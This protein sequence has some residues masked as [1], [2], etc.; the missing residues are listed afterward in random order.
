[1]IGFNTKTLIAI[2]VI[3]QSNFLFAQVFETTDRLGVAIGASLENKNFAN[4]LYDLGVKQ[5]HLNVWWGEIEPTQQ[6]YDYTIIDT[7]LEKLPNDAFAIFRISARKNTWGNIDSPDNTVPADLSVNGSFY[8][9]VY[10]VVIRTNGRVKYFES[11]W[12]ADCVLNH[13]T[14]TASEYAELSRTFYKAVKDAD[15]DAFVIMGG[16]AGS[17]NNN[18]AIANCAQ[19]FFDTVFTDLAN[20]SE[21]KTF[22]VFDIHLYDELYDI[23]ERVKYFRNNLDSYPEFSGTPIIVTEYGGPFP[24][25]FRYVDPQQFFDLTNIELV[26]DPCLLAGDL[27]NTPLYPGGYSNQLRMMFGYGIE[28]SLKDKRDRIQGRQMVQRT[29]LALSEGV[30]QLYWWNIATNA[31]W[32][33]CETGFY[34]HPIFGKMPLTEL[35]SDG[36][37]IPNPTY[38]YYQTMARYLNEVQSVTRISNI[39]TDIYL[40]EL[41]YYDGSIAYV[42]W[43]R[44]DQ[45]SGEDDTPIPFTFITPWSEVQTT[46]LFKEDSPNI[47]SIPDGQLTLQITDTPVFI[48]KSTLTPVENDQN[49]AS[50]T[51]ELKQN[52][53]NPFNTSTKIEY[54]LKVSA[55]TVLRIYDIFG[56]EISTLIDEMKMP[57]QHSTVWNG[58]DN[59]GNTVPNGIYFLQMSA[60]ESVQIKRL[61]LLK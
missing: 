25:E 39:N 31:W 5:T 41:L 17:S 7:F 49:F 48:E 46:E 33:Q 61:M 4:P 3:L 56:H 27:T 42:A 35:Q 15:S 28:S 45:F 23:P 19:S 40:Y 47:Y 38:Y 55:H 16:S 8:N 9:Y 24:S 21:E 44:R 36:T 43:E 10:N 26:N 60:G 51:F 53:P 32:A 54:E 22:D 30:E 18:G 1:M 11:E 52:Y 57:G 14:G 12:E 59:L 58:I 29:V 34:R 37:L 50:K 2:I 20:D 13:W 6:N